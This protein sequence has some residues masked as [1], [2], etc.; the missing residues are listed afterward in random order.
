MNY[1]FLCLAWQNQQ[2]FA[3][4]LTF[5]EIKVKNNSQKLYYNNTVLQ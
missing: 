4:Y 1:Y 5:V 2:A 3:A